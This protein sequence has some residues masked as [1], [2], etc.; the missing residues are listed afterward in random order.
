MSERRVSGNRAKPVCPKIDAREAPPRFKVTAIRG[1]EIRAPGE[2]PG[3]RILGPTFS[4]LDTAVCH[5]I[6]ASFAATS[7]R[8][9]AA[10]EERR[11]LALADALNT[12]PSF[13]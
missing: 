9:S 11:A 3:G 13:R 4:V 10:Y 1:G 8:T 2:P 5:R 7:S 12:D 6:V